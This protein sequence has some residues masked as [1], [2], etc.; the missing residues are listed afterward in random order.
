MKILIEPSNHKGLFLY[1]KIKIIKEIILK[2]QKKKKE[3]K[4]GVLGFA[5]QTDQKK[6]GS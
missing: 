2:I 5:A 6:A 1:I 4:G 3:K